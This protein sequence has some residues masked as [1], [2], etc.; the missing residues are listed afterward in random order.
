[1]TPKQCFLSYSIRNPFFPIL[2]KQSL[3]NFLILVLL[4]AL[5]EQGMV[6]EAQKAL[7]EAEAL[8]KV[9]LESFCVF[10]FLLFFYNFFG[11]VIVPAS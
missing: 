9:C 6:D 8:K 2:F 1:M 3:W 11:G 5:G 10:F 7:E 4:P